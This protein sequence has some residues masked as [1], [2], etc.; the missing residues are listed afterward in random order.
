MSSIVVPGA[1]NVTCEFQYDITGSFLSISIPYKN[2]ILVFCAS[3]CDYLTEINVVSC[4]VVLASKM[5]LELLFNGEF[6]LA[7]SVSISRP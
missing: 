1:K 6:K 2:I 5:Y 7:F 3:I 4:D